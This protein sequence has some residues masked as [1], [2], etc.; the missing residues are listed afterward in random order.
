MWEITP[1]E[2]FNT[3]LD[4]MGAI[5]VIL[6]IASIY[7]HKEHKQYSLLLLIMQFFLISVIADSGTWAFLELSGDSVIFE[8]CL[9]VDYIFMQITVAL[10]HMY[11]IHTMEGKVKFPKGMEY[12]ALVTGVIESVLWIFSKWNGF[13]YRITEGEGYVHGEH[14]IWS[15][16]SGFL[17]VFL[18]MVILFLHKNKITPSEMVAWMSYGVFVALSTLVELVVNV[19]A[20]YVAIPIVLLVMYLEIN[21]QKNLI[22]ARQEVEL[23]ESRTKIA[24]SQIKPHFIYNCLAVI[25]VL[26]R[27]DPEMAVESIGHFSK[28]LRTS[29]DSVDKKTM[30]PFEEEMETIHNYLYLEKLRMQDKLS[31]EEVLSVRD[32]LVPPLSIQ[33]I[34]EN[35]V[36]HGIREKM[37]GG[38]VFIKS[39]ELNQEFIVEIKDDGVGINEKEEQ[40][41][42]N[43]V[44][45]CNVQERIQRI[46]GGYLDVETELGK[47]TCVRLHFPIK[48]VTDL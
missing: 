13:F 11:L 17:I 10:F 36:K 33:P 40:E 23:T 21:L 43:H 31:V 42:R 4:L 30:V 2:A 44:G 27:K 7:L 45:M 8:I 20:L 35:A 32:F 46:C 34:V 47:G 19:P 5:M 39:Y 22:I 1:L 25:Q 9:L 14:F 28:F 3:A 38:T 6:L 48:S 41:A 26:I 37:N 15:Q 18:D 24:M 29:M 16:A 12:L